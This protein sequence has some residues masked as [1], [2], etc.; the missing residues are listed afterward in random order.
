MLDHVGLS[1]GSILVH[2]TEDMTL[3]EINSARPISVVQVEH[4]RDRGRN[5]EAEISG[6]FVDANLP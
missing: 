3:P 5:W 1:L 6:K 2:A 4:L